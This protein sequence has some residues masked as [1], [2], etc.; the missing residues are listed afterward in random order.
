MSKVGLLLREESHD[1][2]QGV[3]SVSETEKDPCRSFGRLARYAHGRIPDT[4]RN[5]FAIVVRDPD[6]NIRGARDSRLQDERKGEVRKGKQDAE[7]NTHGRRRNQTRVRRQVRA[8]DRSNLNEC[9]F[10]RRR[11]IV[12]VVHIPYVAHT[13]TFDT[14]EPLNRAPRLGHRSGDT[15]STS[16]VTLSKLSDDGAWT[17]YR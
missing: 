7:C 9:T 4:R 8:D 14:A 2:E 12:S 15:C 11:Y 13:C 6:G 1:Y 5:S 16:V 3:G 10:T 17:A